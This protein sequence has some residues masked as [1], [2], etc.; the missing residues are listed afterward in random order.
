MPDQE[1]TMTRAR[2]LLAATTSEVLEDVAPQDRMWEYNPEAYFAAG[3][4]ALRCIRLAMLA[5]GRDEFS[6][7]LDF[8]CGHGRVLRTLKAAF[9]D[10]AFTAT[11]IIVRGVRFCAETFGATGV[12]ANVNPA[13]TEL[14]GPF[15]LIW[16][17]SLLTHVGADAWTAT[18]ELWDRTLGPGG[19]AVFTTHGRGPAGALRNGQLSMSLDDE[20][21]DQVV[22][23]YEATGFGFYPSYA[24]EL[25][26]GDSVSSPS[27]VCAHLARTVPSFSLLLYMEGRWLG[28][29][30]VACVK[31]G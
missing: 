20:Q 8:A 18:L 24:P 14:E 28:Q 1:L 30:V 15:D 10:A 7:V 31:Q 4:A 11:D 5:S 12:I 19:L 13:E 22:R 26:H 16:C 3:P 2:E 21:R 29:D 17:G 27:W 25:G 23:E 6:S 9:P